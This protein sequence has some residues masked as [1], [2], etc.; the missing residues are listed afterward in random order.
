[1]GGNGKDQQR[2][3]NLP[4]LERVNQ[5]QGERHCGSRG[6]SRRGR[7]QREAFPLRSD[8]ANG[9]EMSDQFT[10]ST[11]VELLARAADELRI[12]RE[13]PTAGN[14]QCDPAREVDESEFTAARPG[15]GS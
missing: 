4:S 6:H 11:P 7:R 12:A 2:M 10:A 13:A 15:E 5:E 3:R 9:W 1:V 14:E 8:S